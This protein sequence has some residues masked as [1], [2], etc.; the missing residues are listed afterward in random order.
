MASNTLKWEPFSSYFPID[1]SDII[2]S[3][4]HNLA[5]YRE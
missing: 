4:L 1:Q 5:T 3:M 2:H